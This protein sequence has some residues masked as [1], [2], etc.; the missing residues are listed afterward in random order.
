MSR[1]TLPTKA[2]HRQRDLV[3]D[4]VNGDA[5]Y[6]YQR[7]AGTEEQF[8]AVLEQSASMCSCP[9]ISMPSRLVWPTASPGSVHDHPDHFA[10]VHVSAPPRWCAIYLTLPDPG[11]PTHADHGFRIR[12]AP[13]TADVPARRSA[14][15]AAAVCA[16]SGLEPG[17]ERRAAVTQQN[18]DPNQDGRSTAAQ[19]IRVG[20]DA[21][22]LGHRAHKPP[23]FVEY[24][25]NERLPRCFRNRRCS[26][27]LR[28]RACRASRPGAA[29]VSIVP[30]SIEQ[31]RADGIVYVPI[32]GE[33]PRASI[34][35]A[36][37]KDNRSAV[38]R[39]FV[40]LAR[41][42]ARAPD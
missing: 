6:P 10:S 25:N 2:V 26:H 30:H 35:L 23:P 18:H 3:R 34:S 12:H 13:H 5:V 28:A 36:V 21:P 22:R 14:L 41:P 27:Q 20:L 19:G 32:K 37:R 40:A 8:A 24:V 4:M 7:A 1:R 42:R 31:I 33:A 29:V 16:P 9:L 11:V 17:E 39:N 38:I 15:I